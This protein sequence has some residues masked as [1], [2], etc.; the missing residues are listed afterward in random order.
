MPANKYAL[1]RYRV[2]DRCLTNK[3]RLYPSREDLRYAC[4]EALYGSGAD[5]ISLS[6]IDKDIW[7]MKN[8]SELGYYAPISYSR[9]HKGYFYEDE[10]YSISELNLEEEDVE[11]IRFATAILNQFRHVPL[12]AQY[13]SAVEKIIQR[14]NLNTAIEEEKHKALIQF[15]TSTVSKGNEYLGPLL[16]SAKSKRALTLFYQSFKGEEVKKYTIHP[17]LLKE[18]LNRWYLVA[19]VPER[20]KTLTFGLERMVSIESTEERFKTPENFSAKNF[21]KFSMGISESIGNPEIIELEF[22]PVAAKLIETQP[23]HWSQKKL[24]ELQGLVVFQFE[25]HPC[26]ELYNFILSYGPEVKVLKPTSLKKVIQQRITEA[27]Q[28]YSKK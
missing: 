22:S 19:H 11:A 21:F 28:Q 23:L 13:E 10:D 5:D 7:A 8:E 18:Y 15:E 25:I 3:Q 17:L 26:Q 16:E 4:A 9:L 24:K 12:L 20:N 2:I 1:I 27:S 6:T 14:V